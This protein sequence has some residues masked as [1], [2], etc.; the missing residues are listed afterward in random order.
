M[1]KKTNKPK[2]KRY[3]VGFDMIYSHD[4]YV[5][6]P[7]KWKARAKALIKFLGKLTQKDFRID[8]EEKEIY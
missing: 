2:N 5:T 1:A 4:V 7:N 6:A 8:V 3:K